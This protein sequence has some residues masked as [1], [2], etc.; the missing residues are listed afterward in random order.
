MSLAALDD[1]IS[2]L[3]GLADLPKEAAEIAAPLVQEAILGT[4]RAG[5]DPNGTPWTPKKDGAQ[6]LKNAATHIE[7]RAVGTVVRTTLTG[8][9]VFHH[10]GGKR[11]P[12]RQ[13]LPDPGSLP[14]PVEEAL[15]KAAQK[16]FDK[17]V[18]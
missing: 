13:I 4:V 5:Q 10:L 16:A 18:R 2:T 6:P 1:M 9:D 8:V 17:G 7:T 14:K 15:R 12:K 11:N 3:R